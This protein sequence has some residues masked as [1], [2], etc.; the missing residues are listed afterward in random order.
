MKN[1]NDARNVCKVQGAS[2]ASIHSS[3]ENEF[4]RS[5]APNDDVFIGLNDVQIEG[6]FAWSDG[7]LVNFENWEENQPD[8]DFDM[9]D[10]VIIVSADGKWNDTPCE[11]WYG[12][13]CKLSIE[14]YAADSG[15]C[16]SPSN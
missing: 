11:M 15:A 3:E 7:S 8:N 9:E 13:V 5:L 12:Y 10:C 16:D 1:A 14:S 2:L 4:L 6:T